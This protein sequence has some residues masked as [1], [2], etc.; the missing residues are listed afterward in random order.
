MCVYYMAILIELSKTN[1]ILSSFNL[2]AKDAHKKRKDLDE[3][4]WLEASDI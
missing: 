2:V 1:F 3:R 4:I